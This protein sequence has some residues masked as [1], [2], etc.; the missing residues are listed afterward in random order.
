[1]GLQALPAILTSRSSSSLELPL[2]SVPQARFRV[3]PFDR[4]DRIHAGIPQ[5]VR[6][7]RMPVDLVMA[8][9][10]VE[11]G[12]EALNRSPAGLVVEVS[13]ELDRDAIELFERMTEQK[14]LRLRVECGALH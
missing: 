8:Q 6:G 14:Q 3:R 1:M 2:Q 4:E 13:P 9:D 10:A 11:L 5:G 7:V 12:T